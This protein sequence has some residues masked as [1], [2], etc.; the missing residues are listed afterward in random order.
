M[1]SIDLSIIIPC[2]NEE[3]TLSV[4]IEKARDFLQR[5]KI[6]G[7]I[8]IGDNGSIDDSVEISKRMADRVI[9]VELKGYGNVL[10]A[11]I[12]SANGKFVIMGDADDSYDF[13]NLNGIYHSLTSGNHM[14]VGNRYKGGIE[15]NAM[16]FLNKYVGN[17]TITYLG[18][19]LFRIPLNDFN[20]GLRGFERK[21]FSKLNFQS[22]G[23]E[24]ASE[25][26]IVAQLNGLKMVEVPVKLFPDG[27][28]RQSHLRP[29][30]DGIRH[31][32]LILRMRFRKTYR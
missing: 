15:K 31:V 2:L 10:R 14:V 9:H 3:K 27:R 8:I 25:M 17:P 4:C 30:R 7:E 6:N 12:E 32:R 13:S 29:F 16:P 28:E 19:K 24:F 21:A 20:C 18:K 1:Q 22:S 23:M 11:L 26:I 5:E